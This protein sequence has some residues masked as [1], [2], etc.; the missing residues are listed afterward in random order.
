MP[1]IFSPSSGRGVKEK[2]NR[3]RLFAEIVCWSVWPLF[4]WAL[5]TPPS[6]E[7]FSFFHLLAHF[8]T[9]YL[10]SW[11]LLL[12]SFR[13]AG[14]RFDPNSDTLFGGRNT[15]TPFHRFCPKPYKIGVLWNRV[16]VRITNWRR[17]ACLIARP[18]RYQRSKR[19]THWSLTFERVPITDTPS[20]IRM[21]VW[22]EDLKIL[23]I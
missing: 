18:I 8:V 4:V 15:H 19:K 14:V 11:A 21:G 1:E 7:H 3:E 17:L 5:V 6:S 12:F 16:K 13:L 2:S 22:S 20:E 10:V 23:P 9:A